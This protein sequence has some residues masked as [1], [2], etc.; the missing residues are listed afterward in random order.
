[1]P[2]PYTLTTP[3]PAG[4]LRFHELSHSAG[5]SQLEETRL[6][7]EVH[8]RFRAVEERVAVRAVPLAHRQ[9][10]LLRRRDV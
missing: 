4:A 9:E 5:L 3:L 10:H 2:K 8:R 1:M 7:R 6:P